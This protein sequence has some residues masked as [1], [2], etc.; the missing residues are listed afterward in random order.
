M[1]SWKEK[2][3]V[4]GTWNDPD[5]GQITYLGLYAQQH[6]GQEACGIVSLEK[7]GTH[8]IRKGLGLVE[9]VF[10]PENLS[11]LKGKAAIG[12]LRY[13]TAGDKNKLVNTQPLTALLKMGPIAISHNGQLTNAEEISLEL[14]KEGFFFQGT[15]DT[16]CLF[17]LLSKNANE[18]D[19]I[20]ALKSVVRKIEGA[21]SLVILTKE[22]L[23]AVRDP[24]GFRPLVLGH[25]LLSQDSKNEISG[26]NEKSFVLASETCA[27]DLIGAKYIREI[28]PGEIYSVSHKGESSTFFSPFLLSKKNKAETLKNKITQSEMKKELS[29]KENEK[30]ETLTLKN[31]RLHQCIFEHVYFARPDSIVFGLSVYESRKRMGKILAKESPIEADIVVPVPDSGIP[32]ALGYSQESKIPFEFGIIRNH[33]IGRTFIQSHQSIR[34]FSVKVKLNPHKVIAGK[35]VVVVD[36]SLVRGTTS[37]K[38]VHLLRE[39][40]AKE[41]HLRIS[42]PPILSP[43]YYGIDTPEKSELLASKKSVEDIRKFIKADTLNYLSMEGL[44]EAVEGLRENKEIDVRVS[45]KANAKTDAKTNIKTDSVNLV[46]EERESKRFCTSCFNG[47]YV[48]SIKDSLKC[49]KK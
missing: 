48:H 37:R 30:K 1:S 17:P 20:H 12:H 14:K 28:E 40:G 45:S 32:A 5:A 10:N 44:I 24:F 29:S 19:F 26:K 46:K 18:K 31:F 25:R 23:I 15:S 39:A 34:D 8:R 11:H 16:E 21:Y 9:D 41:V 36:D 7:N 35:K 49:L 13:S 4:F 43:C 2:C 47:I 3:A 6:R 33:Y 22:S 27:F 42:S 38:I